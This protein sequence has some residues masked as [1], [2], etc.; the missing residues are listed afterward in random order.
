MMLARLVLLVG[1]QRHQFE[2]G[3]QQVADG[4]AVR[5]QKD[6]AVRGVA[7]GHHSPRR[8]VDVRQH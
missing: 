2:D 8:E 4:E 5:P 7:G 3:V 1:V 6:G